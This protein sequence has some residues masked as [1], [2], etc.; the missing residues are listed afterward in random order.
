MPWNLLTKRPRGHCPVREFKVWPASP[1]LPPRS[2]P[3]S[4]WKNE[5]DEAHRKK[6]L[7]E[8]SG[9]VKF[10]RDSREQPYTWCGNARSNDW[11]CR[12]LPGDA[13]LH[14]RLAAPG[15]RQSKKETQ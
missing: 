15:C 3:V 13:G 10:D 8:H 12:V 1:Q 9:A 14:P 7:Q 6:I 5:T 2:S 11:G 4:S